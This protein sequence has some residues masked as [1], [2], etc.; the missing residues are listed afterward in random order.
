MGSSNHRRKERKQRK[1]VYQKK[2]S[3]DGNNE[4]EE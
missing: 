4:G 2:H 3:R 1:K